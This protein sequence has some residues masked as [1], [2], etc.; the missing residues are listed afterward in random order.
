MA[1]RQRS[2]T[3]PAIVLNLRNYRDADRVVILLTEHQGKIVAIAKGVRKLSS[4]KRAFLQP[5]NIVSCQLINTKA[6]P[7]LSQIRLIKD[8]GQLRSS[9]TQIKKLSQV[10]EILDK[11]TVEEEQPE[12]YELAEKLIYHLASNKPNSLIKQ[13]LVQ[14]IQ[15]AGFQLSPSGSIAETV[16]EITET[17]VKSWEYLSLKG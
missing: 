7:I 16:A 15:V 14:L 1:S 6:M 10:L 17:K 3:T 13:T 9:L 8:V 11:L 12:L 5:G 2:S 4:S